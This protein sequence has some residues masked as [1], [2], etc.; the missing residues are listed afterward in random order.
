[1]TR[2][3][4]EKIMEYYISEKIR[5]VDGEMVENI[6]GASADPQTISLAGGNPA[7]ELFPNEKLAELARE[8]LMEE[9]IK[10]LQY[11]VPAGSPE[12]RRAL[13]ERM[14]RKEGIGK[15]FDR[16][17]IMSGG[18]QG[19]ELVT[20][21]LVDPGDV[22]LVEEPSYL[23]AL[24]I[25]RSHNAKLAGVALDEHGIIPEALEQCLRQYPKARFLYTIPTFQ[26]PSGTTLPLHRRQ[27]IYT[28]AK[29]HGLLILE[30]NP[31]GELRFSG[32]HVPT[33]K[34]LDTEGL[35][36]YCSSFSKILA[37]GLRLGYLILPG[38]LEKRVLVAKQC[39]DVHTPMLVQL[40]ALHFMQRY[41]LDAMI[42]EMCRVYRHKCQVMLEAMEE[43]L[44][45]WVTWVKPRGGLFIWCDLGPGHDALEISR[46]C[47][48]EKVAF[49]PGNVFMTDLSKPCS[50][51]RLN[52]S[53]M[54]DQ[55]IREG[56]AILGK[57]LY[58][59]E[60]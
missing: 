36:I 7:P 8:I 57:V 41:D 26:N 54:S 30:D 60:A 31:Y 34:S 10:A 59:L 39:S 4:E 52:Y 19:V 15:A 42:G 12:L 6:L 11:S 43:Y 16:C 37:P 28:I 50:A 23:G 1:M 29:R 48:K 20:K 9:P 45:K 44:P 2:E 13:L 35:V 58:G 25:F 17:L 32:E 22:V 33:L 55:R 49:V 5:S 24:N 18:Q 27:Q 47:A 14:A 40:M 21:T 38:A 56:I 53:T 51:F 3:Q 46:I